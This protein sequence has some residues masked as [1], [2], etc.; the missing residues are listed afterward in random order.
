MDSLIYQY[1]NTNRLSIIA[2]EL[3]EQQYI[4]TSKSV[5]VGI[6]TFVNGYKHR[7]TGV[8]LQEKPR[9]IG[10]YYAVLVFESRDVNLLKFVEY[11]IKEKIKVEEFRKELLK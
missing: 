11:L 2:D 4:D 6:K 5:C 9:D 1:N 8:L 3:T 10:N 7:T